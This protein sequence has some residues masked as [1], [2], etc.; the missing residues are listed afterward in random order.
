M[1][2]KVIEKNSEQCIYLIS[3]SNFSFYFIIPNSKKVN[4]VLGIFSGIND[5][6]LKKIPK[7]TDRAIVI[8][9][10]NTQ[11]L[12]QIKMDPV[13]GNEYLNNV[14]SFLINTS[15]NI[16]TYNHMEVD[17][18]IFLHQNTDFANFNQQFVS[19]YQGRVQLLD[20]FSNLSTNI[21]EDSLLKNE[22]TPVSSSLNVDVEKATSIPVEDDTL[23]SSGK[24]A[25]VR[26]PG[27]VSY[28]LLGVLVAVVSLVFLYLM[29]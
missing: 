15:Y 14:L 19:K 25:E 5:E 17:S 26:E 9:I 8:P 11:V 21:Q 29:I 4:I 20:L 28:V 24:L 12:E 27:F 13:K 23:K 1:E 7:Q 3:E 22:T 2:Q 10:L 16:L 6:F 18:Q